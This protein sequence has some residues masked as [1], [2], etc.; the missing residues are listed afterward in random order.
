MLNIFL[1][2]SV[3]RHLGFFLLSSS[4]FILL[5]PHVHTNSVCAPV[6]ALCTIHRHHPTAPYFH[7]YCIYLYTRS[8]HTPPKTYLS[9]NIYIY[10]I[11]VLKL[12]SK[13][14]PYDVTRKLSFFTFSSSFPIRLEL[15]II[16]VLD[17][18]FSS[19]FASVIPQLLTYT[20]FLHSYF[21]AIWTS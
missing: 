21:Q 10:V 19:F 16:N 12:R 5:L 8:T 14:I 9:I 20:N 7:M 3:G 2:H 17:F 15:N 1:A 6:Y 11:C 4:Y 13:Q 18:N